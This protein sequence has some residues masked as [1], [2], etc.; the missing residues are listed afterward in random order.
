MLQQDCPTGRKACRFITPQSPVRIPTPQAV[1]WFSKSGD[2]GVIS[3]AG[4]EKRECSRGVW[5]TLATTCDDAAR[6]V[7]SV[8]D[9]RATHGG[10]TSAVARPRFQ[11]KLSP[12]S[13]SRL[14]WVIEELF[15]L[16]G[17]QPFRHSPPCGWYFAVATARRV[18]PGATSP[19]NSFADGQLARQFR[20]GKMKVNGDADPGR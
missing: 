3:K 15:P 16:N 19:I 7:V 14:A 11:S 4:I 1:W 2:R 12:V 20:D 8:D 9:S 13:K 18:R 10:P 17:S 5:P 6:R